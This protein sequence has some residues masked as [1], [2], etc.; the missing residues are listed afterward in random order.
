MSAIAS[1]AIVV[2]TP[3]GFNSV[4]IGTVQTSQINNPS[5]CRSMLVTAV[6]EYS[7]DYPQFGHGDT[8]L[9]Y[10]LNTTGF[11]AVNT[12]PAQYHDNNGFAGGTNLTLF[13]SI[14]VP[15]GGSAYFSTRTEYG[16]GNSS[17]ATLYNHFLTGVTI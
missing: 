17:L 14:V 6:A 13:R 9:Y 2:Q 8:H 15:P 1:T 4:G 16:A 5:A 3:P 12:L 7:M 11:G 10:A